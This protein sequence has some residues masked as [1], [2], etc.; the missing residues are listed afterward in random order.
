[1]K[2]RSILIAAKTRNHT[3]NL[4]RLEEQLAGLTQRDHLK[5]KSL[6]QQKIY[7]TNLIAALQRIALTPPIALI[8]LPAK[9]L[10]TIRGA[11]LIRGTVLEI[12]SRG[13][14]LR[15]DI[16]ALSKIQ[17]AIKAAKAKIQIKQIDLDRERRFLSKLTTKKLEMI[18]KTNAA[19]EL[20][21]IHI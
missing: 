3:F 15:E 4:I 6:S 19:Q 14:I 18:K 13:R 1:M 8:A 20:S 2:Q 12:K 9:P 5:K 17:D 21:L 10:D 7:L 16:K 11:V